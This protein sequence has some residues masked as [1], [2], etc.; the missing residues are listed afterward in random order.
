ML[1]RKQRRAFFT[2]LA[3]VVV[4]F[5]LFRYSKTATNLKAREDLTK[6]KSRG[7]GFDS[8]LL[9]VI[10]FFLSLVWPW[11][12]IFFNVAETPSLAFG[13]ICKGP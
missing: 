10:H 7:C 3:A 9:G 8:R 4:T 2:I 5:E 11:V 6:G 13:Y 1:R 12:K